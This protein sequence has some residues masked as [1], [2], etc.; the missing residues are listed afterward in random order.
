MSNHVKSIIFAAVLSI[1]CSGMLTLASTGLKEYQLKNIAL[2]K[3]KNILKSVGLFAEDQS[4]T[5]DAI[6]RLYADSI[7]QMWV[8]GQGRLVSASQKRPHDLPVYLY[9]KNDAIQAYIIPIDSR[10]LW[11]RILGY[12]ALEND[13]I[14]VAGFTVYSHH[15][16]PGLGGEI[17]RNWFQK[18]FAGK[19]IIDAKGNL[20]A[21]TIAK[22]AVTE[23]IPPDR[24][25]HFVDGI[26][27]ASMTGKFLSMG[28]KQ[29]LI[30][31]E[32]LSKEFRNKQIK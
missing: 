10:G 28:L 8:D 25:K 11:G 31:Y 3:Q 22:G 19:K 32:P 13:G 6:G 2:D 23:I 21:V 16:T 18:N 5:A 4:L 15:E 17:E 1:I 7:K 9:L 12:L 20:V 30:A 27:G 29:T 14:T 26:S 24:R